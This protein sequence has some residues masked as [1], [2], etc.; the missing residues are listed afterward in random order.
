[1]AVN[2]TQAFPA[3]AK[4]FNLDLAQ[5]MAAQ[6]KPAGAEG[7]PAGAVAPE[8]QQYITE[9]QN[10]LA[11]I[12]QGF[13]QKLGTVESQI[14][15]QAESKTNEVLAMWSKDKPHFEAVR[16]TMANL[17]ASGTVPLK[18]GQVDLDGAYDMAIYA[19]PDVRTQVL[20]AQQEAEKKAVA[21]KIEAEKK[22][23]QAQADK[24][25]KAAVAVSGSAPGIPSIAG[26][27]KGPK[28]SVRESIMEA[29]QEL[30]E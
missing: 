17:I 23:Q 11:A 8:V 3:L 2:P 19:M 20:K 24:A 13:S 9:M 28:K 7:Q 1:L 12:E 22:A 10:R 14:Q 15:Q 26:K 5:V 29:R 25:R 6:Q 16:K 4:S 27:P 21:A 18:D 30:E